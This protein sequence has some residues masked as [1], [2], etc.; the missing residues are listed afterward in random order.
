MPYEREGPVLQDLIV[1]RGSMID[2]L[3]DFRPSGRRSIFNF[4]CK[5]TLLLQH[6]FRGS[7]ICLNI[8]F[9]RLDLAAETFQRIGHGIVLFFHCFQIAG[10]RFRVPAFF[11][12]I[13]FFLRFS[14]QLFNQIG[15]LNLCFRNI[16]VEGHHI[17]LR[18]HPDDV[19]VDFRAFS[20]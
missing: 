16:A 3:R 2:L 17:I 9:K 13:F 15:Y 7:D 19:A 4:F 11:F 10:N 14:V 6:L 8:G 12:Q 20:A 5:D 1:D 18:L